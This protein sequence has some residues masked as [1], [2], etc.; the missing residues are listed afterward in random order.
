MLTAANKELFN[1]RPRLQ[2][3]MIVCFFS[4]W[5]DCTL[6]LS[7]SGARCQF[8]KESIRVALLSTSPYLGRVSLRQRHRLPI[9]WCL[10]QR[11]LRPQM[12]YRQHQ[13]YSQ[14]SRQALIQPPLQDSQT[15]TKSRFASDLG[16]G[17]PSLLAAIWGCV[18]KCILQA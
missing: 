2:I 15:R 17:L 8:R 9:P 6:F 13:L 4:F 16:F 18:R 10:H 11:Q 3:L 5:R 12:N 7:L 14:V 1:R